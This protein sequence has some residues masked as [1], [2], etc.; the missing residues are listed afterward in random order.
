MQMKASLPSP[1]SGA[2]LYDLMMALFSLEI[3]CLSQAPGTGTRTLGP[4]TDI[5]GTREGEGDYPHN[6]E[7][8]P[9]RGMIH[10]HVPDCGQNCEESAMVSNHSFT[11]DELENFYKIISIYVHT[12]TMFIKTPIGFGIKKAK[13]HFVK[14]AKSVESALVQILYLISTFLNFTAFTVSQTLVS[15]KN[16][17]TVYLQ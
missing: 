15:F 8:H 12:K 1:C 11:E 9:D 5:L 13:E 7:R 17:S 14:S 2:L 6:H 3:R 4:L 10:A 16:I